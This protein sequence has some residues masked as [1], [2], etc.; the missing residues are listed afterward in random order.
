MNKR[1]I[2]Q[3]FSVALF[4]IA[5]GFGSGCSDVS[6]TELKTPVY[7]TKIAATETK[8]SPFKAEFPDQYAS[9]K[10]NDE[11]SVMTEYKGSVN[12]NKE[13]GTDPLP[14][15]FKYAQPYLKN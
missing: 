7:K 11:S 2:T 8:A 9:Y 5:V 1:S 14:E 15:G 3:I 6:T 12:F 13:N 4:S 10:K